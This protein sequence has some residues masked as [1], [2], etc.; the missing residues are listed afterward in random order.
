M[1]EC[2]AIVESDGNNEL[3]A[4]LDAEAAEFSQRFGEQP[5]TVEEPELVG[6][7]AGGSSASSDGS[8]AVS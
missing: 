4:K 6:A 1:N 5:T 7:T 2:R 8:S 3:I